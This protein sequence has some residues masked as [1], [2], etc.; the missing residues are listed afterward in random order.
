MPRG[1][2]PSAPAPT[3]QRAL[4]L[5]QQALSLLPADQ[6]RAF[7]STHIR[8]DAA[9]A[10]LRRYRRSSDWTPSCP[11]GSNSCVFEGES[12]ACA[13][14]RAAGRSFRLPDGDWLERRTLLAASPL[15]VGRASA[16]RRLQQCGSVALPVHSRRGRS[17]L[18]DAAKRRD[19]RRQHRRPA[20]RQRPDKPPAMFSMRTAR[21]WRSTTSRGATRN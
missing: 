9:L 11:A 16:L 17:L 5:I 19:A 13:A 10:A 2:T 1:F 14:D 4:E 12:R 18:R 15:D 6:R 3:R 21:R 20:G 8:T 7:W